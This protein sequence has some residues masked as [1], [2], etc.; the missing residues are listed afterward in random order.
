MQ[1]FVIINNFEIKMNIDVNVENCLAKIY[2][3]MDLFGILV[4][5]N[6]KVINHVT[7]ENI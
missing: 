2:V 7:L 5:A 4:Y 1:V 6:V 3:M